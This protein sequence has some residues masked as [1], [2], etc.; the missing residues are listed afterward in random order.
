MDGVMCSVCDDEEATRQCLRLGA[1]DWPCPSALC[2]TRQCAECH[3][4]QFHARELLAD[5][6]DALRDA[7]KDGDL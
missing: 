3:E 4:R 2:G 6:G 5:R 7:R 1:G